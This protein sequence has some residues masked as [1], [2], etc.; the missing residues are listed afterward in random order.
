MFLDA[1][2]EMRE[3]LEPE[4]TDWTNVQEASARSI[5]TFPTSF[6]WFHRSIINEQIYSSIVSSVRYLSS[7]I[8]LTLYPALSYTMKNLF[9]TMAVATFAIVVSAS[10]GPKPQLSTEVVRRSEL[11]VPAALQRR[12][13]GPCAWVCAA[14]PG[15]GPVVQCTCTIDDKENKNCCN[16][17]CRHVCK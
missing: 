13:D 2:C 14:L 17:D 7:L 1:T 9:M 5:N 3:C 12:D 16:S 8:T 6:I 11:N 10:P 15:L 4:Q